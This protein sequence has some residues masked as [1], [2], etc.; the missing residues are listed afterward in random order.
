MKR[1]DITFFVA[2][3]LFVG[4]VRAQQTQ[5]SKSSTLHSGNG[6]SVYH[7]R[8]DFLHLPKLIT[9]IAQTGYTMKFTYA[10]AVQ[11]PK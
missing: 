9:R 5:D 3:L 8:T 4:F 2:L 7:R 10:Q 1:K 6:Y 11:K